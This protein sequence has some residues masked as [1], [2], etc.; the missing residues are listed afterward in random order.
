MTVNQLSIFLENRSG[1]LTKVLDI[2]KRTGIRI[3]ASTIADTAQY[4]LFRVICS[5]PRQAYLELVNE[6]FAVAMSDVFA[7]E[8]DNRPGQV[9]DTIKCFSD[10]DISVI[11][12][13]SFMFHGQGLLIFRTDNT[14]EAREVIHRASL[15]SIAEKDLVDWE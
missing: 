11:Y 1:T 7:I 6:G 8:M 10:A 14:E 2:M 12:M 15:K 9:A 4:G 3:I 5:N 13:Y